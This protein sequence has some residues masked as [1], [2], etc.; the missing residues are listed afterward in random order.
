MWLGGSSCGQLRLIWVRSPGAKLLL[1][2]I[3][4]I[5]TPPAITALPTEIRLQCGIGVV[6]GD[7]EVVRVTGFLDDPSPLRPQM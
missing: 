5:A 3:T 4:P 6:V 2:T 1:V 7:A